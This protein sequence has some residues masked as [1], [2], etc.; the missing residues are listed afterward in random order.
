[1]AEI[2]IS[3]LQFCNWTYLE[4]RERRRKNIKHIEEQ[5]IEV[6]TDKMVDPT[7]IQSI[8]IDI[9]KVN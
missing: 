4:F 9:Q 5:N 8:E 6:S 3:G 1:M 2:I 7:P